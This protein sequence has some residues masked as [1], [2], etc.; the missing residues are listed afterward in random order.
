MASKVKEAILLGSEKRSLQADMVPASIYQRLETAKNEE[1]KLLDYITYQYYYQHPSIDLIKYDEAKPIQVLDETETVVSEKHIETLRLIN[2]QYAQVKNY[3][4]KQWITKV[5]ERKQLCN[6][7]FILDLISSGE[8]YNQSMRKNIYQIIGNKG[9]HVLDTF[10]NE[11]YKFELKENLW[12]EGNKDDRKKYLEEIK[13]NDA[14]KAIALV[15]ESWPLLNIKEKIAF[16]KIINEGLEPSA[17]AYIDKWSLE[18]KDIAVDKPATKELKML[19]CGMHYRLSNT[20]LSELKPLLNKYIKKSDTN[21]F[22]K[23]IKVTQNKIIEL[24]AQ[25]DEV[26]NGEFM[27]KKFGFDIKNPD[28]ALYD[29]DSYYW[30]SCL[31]EYLPFSFWCDLLEGDYQQ[32]LQYFLTDDTFQVKIQGIKKSFLE[33]AVINNAIFTK[34][35]K[36]ISNLSQVLANH[37]IDQLIHLLNKEDFESYIINNQYYARTDLYHQRAEYHDEKWSLA[38]AKK[39]ISYIVDQCKSNNYYYNKSMGIILSIFLDEEGINEFMKA[40]A[41]VSSETWY[42]NFKEHV[43]NPV[44]MGYKIKCLLSEL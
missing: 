28:I 13:R 9:R 30:L 1:Q 14:E 41:K 26:W 40:D 23:L 4:L 12:Q 37:E 20:S 22:K 42:Q 10:P 15:D 29:Y 11:K 16:A 3:Y 44:T 25:I 33:H 34:D 18:F 24:P 6:A 17:L 32:V 35:Q 36:L 27:N 8:N 39:V 5:A 38:L 2:L 43:T 21:F 7:R 19:L 31:V